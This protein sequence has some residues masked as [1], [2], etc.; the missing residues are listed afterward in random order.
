MFVFDAEDGDLIDITIIADSDPTTETHAPRLELYDPGRE[1]I[2]SAN[3]SLDPSYGA[4]S[5]AEQLDEDGTYTLIATTSSDVNADPYDDNTDV[6]FDSFE[7]ELQFY[8]RGGG[9]EQEIGFD[10][11]FTTQLTNEALYA[12]DYVGYHD[13][14]LFDAEAGDVVS[15]EMRVPVPDEQAAALHLVGPDGETLE[16]ETTDSGA[17][18]L[19]QIELDAEGLHL[20]IST[21]SDA[22]DAEVYDETIDA[23]TDTF[24]YE[25]RFYEFVGERELVVDGDTVNSLLE[26]D[27]DFQDSL[28]GYYDPYVTTMMKNDEFSV[29]MNIDQSHENAAQL[30]VLDPDGS[31]VTSTNV[32]DGHAE[33]EQ[34]SVD[35][36]GEYT[37]IATTEWSSSTVYDTREEAE[38]ATFQYQLTFEGPANAPPKIESA[39][40]RPDQAA[41]FER[42]DLVADAFDPNDKS[43]EYEW[44]QVFG[45][46]PDPEVGIVD[47]DTATAWF[48]APEVD[49]ENELTFEVT[50]EDSDGGTV[51]Q[52]VDTLI[53]PDREP[54]QS[55][56]DYADEQSSI[57][58]INGT[59]E[60]IDDWVSDQIDTGLLSD[61]IDA[62]ESGDPVK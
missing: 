34:E 26:S 50:V 51:T 23:R 58:E 31:T 46:F 9:V 11:Q 42:V 41:I 30:I 56:R 57:V 15:A 13:R 44:E 32:S 6:Y 49:A 8:D 59:R 25:L 47:G 48:E 37:I 2:T 20:L 55:I 33:I 52:E 43:L 54:A 35:K 62:W 45:Q 7:Y 5:L 1:F 38:R 12:H 29:Y 14:Y 21:T 3:T 24:E 60:A 53:D 36:T 28:V 22:S 18:R 10:E 17:A 61:V 40:A 4:A 16:T 27:D 39:E 19:D